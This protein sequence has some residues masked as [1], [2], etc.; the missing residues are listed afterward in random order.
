MG[1]DRVIVQIRVMPELCV[2][3]LLV[4]LHQRVQQGGH[5]RLIAGNLPC[6]VNIS[7]HGDEAVCRTGHIHFQPFAAVVDVIDCL[8]ID[9]IFRHAKKAS[10]SLTGR[11]LLNVCRGENGKDGR[12]C[13][14]QRPVLSETVVNIKSSDAVA[15][16][17][18]DTVVPAH[19]IGHE[20]GLEIGESPHIVDLRPFP[21]CRVIGHL[22]LLTASLFKLPDAEPA[23]TFQSRRDI[24]DVYHVLASFLVVVSAVPML[25]NTAIACSTS[26]CLAVEVKLPSLFSRAFFP[27]VV[28]C[29]ASATEL[30]R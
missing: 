7:R 18:A 21:I 27:M 26:R 6:A 17:N 20:G 19:G 1:N 11:R 12:C 29:S 8:V 2:L 9:K 23:V 22:G 28:T 13:V 30:R 24:L 10:Q 5:S 15:D 16:R 25:K 4:A 3:H 14:V